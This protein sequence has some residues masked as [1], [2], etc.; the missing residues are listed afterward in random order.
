M[1]VNDSDKK[2][3]AISEK[4]VEK[5]N[6]LG[7]FQEA[8]GQLFNI[9]AEQRNN[10]N[11]Q[12]VISE[13]ETQNNQTLAQA[14][15]IL[16]ANEAGR[17]VVA[18][19]PQQL[20]PTT[21]AILG[22][23]GMGKPGTMTKTKQNSF[24]TQ[25]GPQRV[26]ITNNTTTTTNNN[27]QLT[28]P[29]IPMSQPIIP[30]RAAAQANSSMNNFK[31]W[32]NNAFAKQNEAAAIREKEYRRREWSLTR[33]ANKMIRKMGEI[34]KGIG[35]SLSPKNLSN[36]L[37]DQFKVV[38]TLMGLHLV[39]KNIGGI[40]K[41]IEEVVSF[42]TGKKDGQLNSDGKGSK[43]VERIKDFLKDIGI[44][45]KETTAQW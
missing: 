23:Y 35:D 4:R 32:V 37:G 38:L 8:Q 40:L 45:F 18:A 5:G 31:V 17:E 19:Q 39:A 13:M 11:E 9:Q 29:N 43:F 21:R 12:R 25:Q 28:Q 42:F 6:E 16:A 10:L 36:A 33:S 2:T 1:A 27:I 3:R 7:Q 34:G 22:K 41:G 24:Q 14:A 15:G 44:F 26:N 30:M 20:N